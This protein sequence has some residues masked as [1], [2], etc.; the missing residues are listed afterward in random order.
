[1][2]RRE[3]AVSKANRFAS[4]TEE[5]QKSCFKAVSPNAPTKRRAS[6]FFPPQKGVFYMKNPQKSRENT[7]KNEKYC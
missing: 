3:W 7:E 2:H 6:A 5:D 4:S 1:M